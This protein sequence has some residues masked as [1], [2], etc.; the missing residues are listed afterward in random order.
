MSAL[1]TAVYVLLAVL[2]HYPPRTRRLVVSALK[3]A[4]AAFPSGQRIA[5]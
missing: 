3:A 4:I 1:N 5:A 2:Y